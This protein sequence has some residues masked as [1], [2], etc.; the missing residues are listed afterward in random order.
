MTER[1]IT[2]I[3][4]IQ[5]SHSCQLRVSVSTWREQTKVEISDFSA[6]IPGT[7]FQAGNGI[8]LDINL[9][10]ELVAILSKAAQR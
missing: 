4:S 9:L 2:T 7:F 1:A 3:G 5:K 8:T 10:P 6:V